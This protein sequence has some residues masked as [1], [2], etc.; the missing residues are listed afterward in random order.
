[1]SSNAPESEQLPPDIPSFND[2]MKFGLRATNTTK[3]HHEISGERFAMGLRRMGIDIATDSQLE[4]LI[5][6]LHR[7][8]K[9]EDSGKLKD[10]ADEI[11]PEQF[12]LFLSSPIGC[13][14]GCVPDNDLISFE[15][16]QEASQAFKRAY[17]EAT[18]LPHLQLA[19]LFKQNA[20]AK[21]SMLR[22]DF[23]ASLRRLKLPMHDSHLVVLAEHFKCESRMQW[24]GSNSSITRGRYAAGVGDNAWNRQQVCPSDGAI[25][26]KTTFTGYNRHCTCFWRRDAC[27]EGW[28]VMLW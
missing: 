9:H 13:E 2:M 10:E 20:V 1:L 21:P 8:D 3:Q 7:P 18:G 28:M 24:T 4:L 14:T 16:F 17:R 23:L 5:N 11:T 12:I 6:A 15:T 25:F 22:S 19:H 27:L 26:L